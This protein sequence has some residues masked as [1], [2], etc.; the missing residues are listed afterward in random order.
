MQLLERIGPATEKLKSKGIDFSLWYKPESLH[1]DLWDGQISVCLLRTLLKKIAA[2]QVLSPFCC[3]QNCYFYIL[4]IMWF[5]FFSLVNI[6]WLT[7]SQIMIHK[8]SLATDQ[9]ILSP[10][11]PP[12]TKTH[13]QTDRRT[14]VK[15]L[16]FL[17]QIFLS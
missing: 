3:T 16:F 9:R 14:W 1:A 11:P 12:Q 2:A 15:D 5:H 17:N 13:A 8:T 6:Y 10:L 7:S 4:P